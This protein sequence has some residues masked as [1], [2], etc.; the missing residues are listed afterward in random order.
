M[1]S[2]APTHCSSTYGTTNRE[3]MA[4]VLYVRRKSSLSPAA[5]GGLR[6]EGTSSV[7]IGHAVAPR[8]S[9]DE[10]RPERRKTPRQ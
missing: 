6:I 9:D 8:V 3:S 1:P 5:G 7:D 2:T 4:S 10:H